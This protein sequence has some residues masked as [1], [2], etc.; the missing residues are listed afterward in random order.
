MSPAVARPMAAMLVEEKLLVRPNKELPALCRPL[1]DASSI[2][3]QAA[4][5]LLT[6]LTLLP[7]EDLEKMT[8][9]TDVPAGTSARQ[10]LC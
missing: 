2:H 7:V 3:N 8:C 6:N 9:A 5:K 1:G 10:A 4:T